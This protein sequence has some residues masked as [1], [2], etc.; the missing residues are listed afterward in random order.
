MTAIQ[1]WVLRMLKPRTKFAC[2]LWFLPLVLC[3]LFLTGSLIV[4]WEYLGFGKLKGSV[5]TTVLF[6]SVVFAV[7]KIFFPNADELKKFWLAHDA[8]IRTQRIA[9]LEKLA[10]RGDARAACDLGD[11]CMAEYAT[12]SNLQRALH[13]FDLASAKLPEA[14][15]K[16]SS[17]RQALTNSALRKQRLEIEA[18]IPELWDATCPNCSELLD[19]SS[20]K[21]LR[22]GAIFSAS[23]TEWRPIRREVTTLSNPQS[24]VTLDAKHIQINESASDDVKRFARIAVWSAHFCLVASIVTIGLGHLD[25]GFARLIVVSP[26]LYLVWAALAIIVA[27]KNRGKHK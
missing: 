15:R 9:E 22:C 12:S 20:V 23:G 19:T 2:F 24:Q 8:N 21:C 27:I 3:A 25:S 1:K 26:F 5:A 16:A 18:K 10:S 13:W 14:E 7:W 11:M 4:L 17:T 6:W